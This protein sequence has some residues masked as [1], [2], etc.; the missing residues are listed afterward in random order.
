[1][2]D[3]KA[4]ACDA[5]GRPCDVITDHYRPPAGP[6]THATVNDR[7]RGQFGELGVA[8]R[9]ANSFNDAIRD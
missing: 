1:M 5:G 7:E 4:T 6:H 2:L 9:D 3:A 8:G